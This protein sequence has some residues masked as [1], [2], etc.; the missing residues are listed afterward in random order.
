MLPPS[1]EMNVSVVQLIVQ[2][3]HS[4]LEEAQR[5]VRVRRL[6]FVEDRL[7]LLLVPEIEDLLEAEHS[8][9]SDEVE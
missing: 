9:A 8:P 7:S 4:R 2:A 1:L 6:V 5:N 3:L